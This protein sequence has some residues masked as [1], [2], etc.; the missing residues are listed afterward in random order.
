MYKPKEKLYRDKKNSY[1]LY[2]PYLKIDFNS[3]CGYCGIHH[4]YFGSGNAFH[5]DHFAPKSL[6]RELENDYS[7]LVYSCPICNIA[8]SNHWVGNAPTENIVGNKGF[9]DPCDIR[10]DNAFYRDYRGKIKYREEYSAA[11]YMYKKMKFG[12]KR[13]ELF[14]LADYFQN[15]VSE[16]SQQLDDLGDKHPLFSDIDELLNQSIRQMS[17]YHKLTREL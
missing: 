5:I 14:W 11:E 1:R 4:V 3:C 17:K 16:L 7:N 10:Y 15:I 2:K 8:K 6:F 9:Y 12:L 13:H